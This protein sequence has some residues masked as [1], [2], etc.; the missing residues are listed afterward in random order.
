MLLLKVVESGQRSESAVLGGLRSC[1]SASIPSRQ[2]S[3]HTAKEAAPRTA[4]AWVGQLLPS[5]SAIDG[6]A[7]RE[8]VL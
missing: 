4:V 1:E 7:S 3:A 8:V 2:E 6:L 5:A